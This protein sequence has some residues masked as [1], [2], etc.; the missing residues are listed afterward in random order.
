MSE[1]LTTTDYPALREAIQNVLDR[2]GQ[3]G[4]DETARLADIVAVKV[5]NEVH[6]FPFPDSIDAAWAAAEAALPEGW[7]IQSVLRCTPECWQAW[8]ADPAED[9]SDPFVAIADGPT[10][11]A[12]LRSLAAK[13]RETR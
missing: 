13:L 12:A 10:P 2:D 7:V 8:A 3:H 5:W 6:Q 11:A 4:W 1:N 9:A